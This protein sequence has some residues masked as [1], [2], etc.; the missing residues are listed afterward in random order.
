MQEVGVGKTYL[1]D[2]CHVK[3]VTD[4]P[5]NKTLGRPFDIWKHLGSCALFVPVA[6]LSP[7]R[8]ATGV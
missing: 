3:A 1:Y 4:R 2:Q 6:N 7:D 8:R 5:P